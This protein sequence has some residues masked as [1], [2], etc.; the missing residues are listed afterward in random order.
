MTSRRLNVLVLFD[1]HEPIKEGYDFSEEL[2]TED[3]K[4][5]ANILAALKNLE[6]QVR[7]IAVHNNVSSI[8]DEIKKDRP[9]IVFNLVE[10][11]NG[12]S[13]QE[14]NVV[15]L[16]ELMEIPYTG[17]GPAGMVLCKNKALTKKILS[18][19][20]VRI[21]KFAVFTRGKKIKKLLKLPFPL[22]I[23][24]LR[25]DASYGIAQASFVEKNEDLIERIKFIHDN[26]NEDALVEEYIDGRELYVSILGNDRLEVLPVREMKFR[27]VPEAEPK[28]ATFKAKWDQEYRKRW[29]INE[30]FADPLPAEM[31]K[32]IEKLCK[33]IYRILHISGYGRLD[34]RMSPQNELIIIEANPNPFL[35]ADEDFAESAKKAGYG[36]EE[37]IQR[38]INLG[39]QHRP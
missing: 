5:E 14:R 11:F 8:I 4:A 37:L 35:A 12:K 19:H 30:G 24:P 33:K 36:F 18:H 1:V 13:Y 6:H 15:S 9:D 34:L 28:I 7:W 32:K 38:I 25:D 31:P 2:K 22:I 10:E 27:E 20:H 17:T 16:L 23:K 29:R 39:L 21:S 3:W 26:L